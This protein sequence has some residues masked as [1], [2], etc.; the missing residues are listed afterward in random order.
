MPN[1]KFIDSLRPLRMPILYFSDGIILKHPE[2]QDNFCTYY[3]KKGRM[4]CI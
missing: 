1:R 2:K 4:L 3:D